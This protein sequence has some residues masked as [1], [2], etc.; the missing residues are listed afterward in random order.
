[1]EEIAM[2]T[3]HAR[4]LRLV[5]AAVVAIVSA[6]VAAP[7]RASLIAA[8]DTPAMVERADTI[9]VVD[10]TSVGAAWD[11]RHER[12]VTTVELTVVESWKGAVAPAARVV[13]AQ[14]GGTVGDV[15]MTVFGMP[16]F[17]PG[18]RALVFLHGASD[19]AGVVGLAQGKRTLRPDPAGGRWLVAAPQRAGAAFVRTTTS[20]PR[21]PVLAAGS[22]PLDEVRAEI[23]AEI[24]AQAARRGVR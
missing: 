11:F 16:R 19:R 4:L 8:L 17:A 9:A 12:I 1:M 23:R 13:V 21:P 3:G 14:P 2:R 6:A 5:L 22:R 10:V 7:G 20:G 18:E 24:D 15:T